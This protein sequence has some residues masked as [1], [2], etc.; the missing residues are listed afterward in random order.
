[1]VVSKYWPAVDFLPVTACSQTMCP[2]FDLGNIVILVY[3]VW[4][5]DTAPTT[6]FTYFRRA[7]RNY[8]HG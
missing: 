6:S 1:M 7:E 8:P 5:G 4:V 2:Y 3:L